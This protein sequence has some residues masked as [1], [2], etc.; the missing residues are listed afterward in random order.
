MSNPRT[1]KRTI[2]D[3]RFS[4]SSEALITNTEQCNL[5]VKCQCTYEIGSV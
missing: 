2:L 4:M 1:S 3:S 5:L